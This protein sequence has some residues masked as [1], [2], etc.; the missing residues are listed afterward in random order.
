[1]EP[2]RHFCEQEVYF[3]LQV[4]GFARVRPEASA[5]VIPDVLAYHHAFDKWR[6]LDASRL[7]VRIETALASLYALRKTL[8]ETQGQYE[9]STLMTEL[10]D[11]LEEL[12]AKLRRS[13]GRATAAEV[14]MRA[15]ASAAGGPG[16]QRSGA[17]ALASAIE[18]APIPTTISSGSGSSSV[19]GP[20]ATRAA[21]AFNR[22]HCKEALA[23]ELLL[24]PD[25]QIS[26]DEE[27]PLLRALQ[28]TFCAE[29]FCNLL[30]EL[31]VCSPFC[32]ATV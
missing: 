26:E 2:W 11:K 6:K 15:F 12:R 3:D 30:A 16:V 13:F 4:G 17:A 8:L 29:F 21:Q 14:D 19:S 32:C 7:S 28:T 31:K 1:M 5:A 10:D 20:N 27:N 24:N 23:H 25:F 22:A 9:S 18:A